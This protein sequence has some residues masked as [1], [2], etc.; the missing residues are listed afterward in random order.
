MIQ[1]FYGRIWLSLGYHLVLS[2]FLAETWGKKQNL[3]MREHKLGFPRDPSHSCCTGFN[4]LL[5]SQYSLCSPISPLA[6]ISRD[7]CGAAS[8]SWEGSR[9]SELRYSDYKSEDPRSS[10]APILS[11]MLHNLS[12]L[13]FPGVYNTAVEPLWLLLG[14]KILCTFLLCYFTYSSWFGITTLVSI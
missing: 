8:R 10:P 6:S 4:E 14:S 1:Y 9:L 11:D 2:Y 3:N 7:I 13:L 5:A 12:G